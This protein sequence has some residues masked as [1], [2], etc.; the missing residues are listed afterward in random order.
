[1]NLWAIVIK[2]SEGE[3]VEGNLLAIGLGGPE[4]CP[5]L[6]GDKVGEYSCAVHEKPWFKKMG[7]A[8]YQSHWPDQ[9]C[10]LG[11][12]LVKEEKHED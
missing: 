7:C 6:R 10:R 2:D 4:R 9:K 1:M 11:E 8:E 5:H 12:F 3:L